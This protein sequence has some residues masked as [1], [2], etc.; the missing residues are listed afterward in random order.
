MTIPIEIAHSYSRKIINLTEIKIPQELQFK[1]INQS[2][3]NEFVWAIDCGIELPE[4]S[5][6]FDGYNHWLANNIEIW[7]AA[8]RLNFQDLRISIVPGSQQDALFYASHLKAASTIYPMS[9]GS[10][11]GVIRIL[12]NDAV[13]QKWNDLKIANHC[14]VAESSVSILRHQGIK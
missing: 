3:V 11:R 8:K 4:L 10:Q 6:F 7:E 12:L 5:L 1:H 2:I 14:G 13:W 9:T